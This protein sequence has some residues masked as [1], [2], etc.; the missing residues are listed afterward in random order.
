MTAGPRV[1]VIGGGWAG[2]AAAVRA[3]QR[4]ASVTLME[5]APQLGG[6]ARRVEVDGMPLDNG[7]HIMIGAY[8]ATLGLM[9][10]LGVDL[11][12][13]VQ[14]RP[15]QLVEPDGRGLRLPA[16]PALPAFAVAVMRRDGWRLVDK[17]RLL[18]TCVGW[19]LQGFRCDPLATVDALCSGLP[20][21]I[22][23][24]LIE[25]LCVAALNTEARDASA[26]VFLRVLQ[27][28]L[29]GG[30]GAADLL[31]PRVDLG[32]L[33]ADPAQRWLGERAVDIRLS[34]RVTAVQAQGSGWS[35][36]GEPFDAVL[37][38]GTAVEAARLVSAHRPDWAATAAALRY[39]PI[40]TVYARC[41]G[42]RL[43]LPMLALQADDAEPAQFV[44]DRGALTPGDARQ[45][46]LLAFVISGAAPWVERGTAA[47]VQA[48]LAQARR[49]LGPLL[50]GRDIE[51]LRMLVDKR[52]TFACTP[53]LARPPAAVAPGWWAA[54]DYVAGP[55]PATL[56]AAVRS[57]Q[58]AA[59]AAM[60]WLGRTAPPAARR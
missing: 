36:D 39:E 47:T 38:C 24:D 17:L 6:R 26:T 2:L 49:Q 35:V 5:M 7:Q 23:R 45:Q 20:E 48:T 32:T 10:T 50:A 29:A 44:F 8:G 22:R 18:A 60:D 1:A 11:P 55:Y 9:A 40:A 41:P 31:L 34:R 58:A 37:M 46:G 15:L 51:P 28:S 56:E 43:P 54:G 25:P 3:V 21:R 59:N 12:A 13:S 53:G 19:Q 30:R 57:G 52:A 33:L 14:R 4:G 16:G 42:L 27:D